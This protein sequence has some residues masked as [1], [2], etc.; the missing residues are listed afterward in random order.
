[1]AAQALTCCSAMTDDVHK[2]RQYSLADG[3]YQ[4]AGTDLSIGRV[5]DWKL[6]G[7]ID[8]EKS[9]PVIVI[10]AICPFCNVFCV[11]MNTCLK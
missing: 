11:T 4:T 2:Q 1:M 3:F 7:A 10:P 9:V 6:N 5:E 8:K